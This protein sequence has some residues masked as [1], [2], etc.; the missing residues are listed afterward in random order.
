MEYSYSLSL[1]VSY[2]TYYTHFSTHIYSH[3]LPLTRIFCNLNTHITFSLSLT[4]YI[5][6]NTY[7][8]SHTLSLIRIFCNILRHMHTFSHYTFC[9]TRTY[10]LIHHDI[11]R[12]TSKHTSLSLSV[13][14]TSTYTNTHIEE[15]VRGRSKERHTREIE[16]R[17]QTWTSRSS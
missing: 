14:H 15:I 12:H 6:F 3:I 16:R 2:Y 17:T 11:L 1:F 5:H 7:I 13:K 8:R 10:S 4:Y 9:N